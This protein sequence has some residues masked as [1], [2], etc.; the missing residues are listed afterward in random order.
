MMNY[1]QPTNVQQQQP[2]Q[3]QQQQ[4]PSP[5]TLNTPQQRGL[6]QTRRIPLRKITYRSYFCPFYD[7]KRYLTADFG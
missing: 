4:Q 7:Q 1:G 2:P 6:I 5:P 3:Q